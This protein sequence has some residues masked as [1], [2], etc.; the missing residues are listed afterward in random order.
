[1]FFFQVPA[2]MY[3]ETKRICENSTALEGITTGKIFPITMIITY[4]LMLYN[5]NKFILTHILMFIT[6]C[7][8]IL[9]YFWICIM[10]NSG[11][12]FNQWFI[13]Y[14]KPWFIFY[15]ETSHHFH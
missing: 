10:L 9:N 13:F 3:L 6:Y 8:S 14:M 1:M 12:G 7:I 4:I 2:Y 15:R 5:Y 11:N